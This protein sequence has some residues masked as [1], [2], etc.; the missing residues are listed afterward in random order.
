M[1]EMYLELWQDASC[2]YLTQ[3]LTDKKIILAWRPANTKQWAIYSDLQHD[4]WEYF[5]EGKQG[6]LVK[7]ELVKRY[8]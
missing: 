7:S 8:I 1:T 5:I 2:T 6:R 3:I 4:G